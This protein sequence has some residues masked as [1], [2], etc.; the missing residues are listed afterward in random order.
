MGIRTDITFEISDD[1]RNATAVLKKNKEAESIDEDD[2]VPVFKGYGNAHEPKTY[3]DGRRW[4]MINIPVFHGTD[5]EP[6][7]N[8]GGGDWV[9][10]RPITS[11]WTTE[12]N[13]YLSNRGEYMTVVVLSVVQRLMFHTD[14]QRRFKTDVNPNVSQ[15]SWKPC[16]CNDQAGFRSNTN[17]VRRSFVP[18]TKRVQIDDKLDRTFRDEDQSKK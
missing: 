5:D 7:R 16:L 4:D 2:I 6:S 1:E 17:N 11:V 15:K 9:R 8:G 3:G 14:Y 10:F 13:N 12:R 18:T